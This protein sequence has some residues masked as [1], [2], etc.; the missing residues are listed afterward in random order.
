MRGS[1]KFSIPSETMLALQAACSVGIVGSLQLAACIKCTI[2]NTVG[3]LSMN[4]QVEKCQE[5]RPCAAFQGVY[6]EAGMQLKTRC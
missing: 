2:S 3:R 6:S 1:C 4:A 5:L